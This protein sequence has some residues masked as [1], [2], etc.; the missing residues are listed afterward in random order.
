MKAAFIAVQKLM[1]KNSKHRKGFRIN[2]LS[3]VDIVRHAEEELEELLIANT[4]IDK[5][6]ELADVFAC[7]IHFALANGWTE[8]EVENDILNKLSARF[9]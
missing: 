1:D 5:R 8:E 9:D 3:R 2:D 6:K 4:I 7:L